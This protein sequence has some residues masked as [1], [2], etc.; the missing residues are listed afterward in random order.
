M[1]NILIL[2]LI[3]GSLSIHAKLIDKIAGVISDN[4]F[5]LSEINRVRGTLKFRA[6]IAPFIYTKKSYTKSDILHLLQNNF[7]IKDKLAELGF[8]ISDDSVESRITDTEKNLG[9]NRTELHSFLKS[10]SV[11]FNEYFEL[12]REAMEFNIFNSTIISPLVTITDQELK[13]FYITKFATKNSKALSFK[14][15]I[16]GFTISKS[17]ILDSDLKRFPGILK[18]YKKS[19]NIPSIYSSLATSDLGTLAADD[20]PAVFAKALKNTTDN[21]FTKAI[22][23][24]GT[25]HVF[26]VVK[27]ELAESADFLKKKPLIYNQLFQTRSQSIISAWFSKES[28]NYYIV[29]NL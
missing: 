13:N 27:R 24:D 2:T 26:Y 18:E 23:K 5:T 9:L 4:V 12:I 29:N 17:K 16:V 1:K 25:V 20:L 7:I 15:K 21:T 11:S 19:G 8:V 22:V 3:L 28:L 10:K 14:Y 6:E